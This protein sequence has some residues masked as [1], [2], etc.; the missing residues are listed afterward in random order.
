MLYSSNI[1]LWKP[2]ELDGRKGTQNQILTVASAIELV[3]VTESTWVKP[4]GICFPLVLLTSGL[5]M[6][7]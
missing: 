1:Q 3:K 2:L 4:R 6:V 5:E 7:N